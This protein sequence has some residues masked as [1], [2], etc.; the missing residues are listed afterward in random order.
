MTDAVHFRFTVDRYDVDQC[1]ALIR[2]RAA[3]QVDAIEDAMNS[4]TDGWV[5][6]RW[7][8]SDPGNVILHVVAGPR[9]LDFCSHLIGYRP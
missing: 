1:I 6:G 9:L 8:D 5:D 3:D 2:R 4:L 7:N